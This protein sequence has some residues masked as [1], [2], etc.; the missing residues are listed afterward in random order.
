MSITDM[1][2]QTLASTFQTLFYVLTR[3]EDQAKSLPLGLSE[4]IKSLTSSLRSDTPWKTCW[5][6]GV[7]ST[8]LYKTKTHLNRLIMD[9]VEANLPL[10]TAFLHEAGGQ[11]YARDK[12]GVTPLHVALKFQHWGLA[13]VMVRNMGG[14]LYVSDVHGHWPTTTMPPV[15]QL[16][17]EKVSFYTSLTVYNY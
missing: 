10:T 13:E 2:C 8:D 17:L 16:K 4:G 9:A 3:E 1:S 15:L 11:C 12:N 6:P 7:C 14:C 5:V